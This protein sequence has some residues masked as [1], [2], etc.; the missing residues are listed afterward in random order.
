M[1]TYAIA[2]LRNVTMGP[3]ILAYLQAIDATMEPFDGRFVLHG[4]GNKRVLEGSFSGD[5]VMIAFPDRA[6][7][8]GWYDSPAYRAI[9]QLR[10]E[11]SDGDVILMDGVGSD[12]RATDILKG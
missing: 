10:T 2:Q 4:D 3:D 1:T 12:H 5:L 9:L 11:N 8:E 7:A 6:A